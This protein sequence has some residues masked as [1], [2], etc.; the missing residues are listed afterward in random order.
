[1]FTTF[2]KFFV[3]D[4]AG[5]VFARFDMDGFLYDG[6]SAASKGLPSSILLI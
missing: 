2:H 1:M 3:D 5:K 4:F 6:I